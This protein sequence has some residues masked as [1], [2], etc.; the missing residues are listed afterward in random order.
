MASELVKKIALGLVPKSYQL[1]LRY[2]YEWSLGRLEPEMFVLE[3]L[4][5]SKQRV[6][7]IGAN[8]GLYSYY[9]AKK[10]K[11][12]EAFEPLPECARSIAAY[13]SSRIRL[14]N[15]AL[16]ST[17]GKCNCSPQSLT[18][19][20]ILPVRALPLPMALMKSAKSL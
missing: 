6:I 10:G 17:S 15:V 8:Y 18:V 9:L 3:K 2:C 12:V 13:Q 5:G 19:S 4:V 16:S 20:L 14:H 11:F 7:D 1:P